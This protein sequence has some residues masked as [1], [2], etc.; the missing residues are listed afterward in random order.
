MTL[1][2]FMSGCAKYGKLRVESRNVTHIASS[3]SSA[4]Y[5][6]KMTI[7]KLVNNWKDYDIYYAGYRADRATGIMFDPKEDDLRLLGDWWEKIDTKESLEFVLKWINF[8]RTFYEVIP[9]Y[10]MIGPGDKVYGYMYISFVNSPAILREGASLFFQTCLPV[11]CPRFDRIKNSE[12]PTPKTF[13]F[14]GP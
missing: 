12:S 5:S 13:F 11:L 7:D 1:I 2:F 6:E 9:L 4:K 14:L 3:K 10:R 8:P